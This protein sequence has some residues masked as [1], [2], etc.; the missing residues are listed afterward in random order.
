[1]TAVTITQITPPELETLIENL[2]RKILSDQKQQDHIDTDRWLSLEELCQ[3]LPDHPAK[4][5]VYGYVS[6]D[7]IPYH[8]GAKRLRFLKSE[9]DSWN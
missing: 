4:A 9:I 8:K 6:N 5:T 7:R 1:M 3:Y 2:L